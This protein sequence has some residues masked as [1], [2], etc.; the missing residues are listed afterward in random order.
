MTGTGRLQEGSP[1]DIQEDL[2]TLE[3]R[4]ASAVRACES[5]RATGFGEKY[6]E[7]YD[8]VEALQLQLRR[9]LRMS[10]KVVL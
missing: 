9:R 7:A 4:I 6:I 2:P 3:D 8:L 1:M 5:W 10:P